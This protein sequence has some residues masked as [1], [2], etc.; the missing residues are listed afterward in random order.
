M[1]AK[2]ARSVACECRDV[3]LVI[4]SLHPKSRM[5]VMTR[6]TSVFAGYKFQET[7]VVSLFAKFT[8]MSLLF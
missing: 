5:E 7:F 6:N 1:E 2:E 8:P 4:T 3:F